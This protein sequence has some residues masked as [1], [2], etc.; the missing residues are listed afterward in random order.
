MGCAAQRA[1]VPGCLGRCCRR[2]VRVECSRGVVGWW[3]GRLSLDERIA[4][5]STGQLNEM[6]FSRCVCC[7]RSPPH[8]AYD[9]H[10]P[11]LT[12]PERGLCRHGGR[13]PH[14]PHHCRPAPELR[15]GWPHLQEV[16]RR[17]SCFWPVL[18]C[19]LKVGGPP[20]LQE[21]GRG[22]G[23]LTVTTNRC[24]GLLAV[25]G[26]C[27][28]MVGERRRPWR[29]SHH[30]RLAAAT[31]CLPQCFPLPSCCSKMAGELDLSAMLPSAKSWGKTW[32]QPV[33]RSVPRLGAGCLGVG[34]TLCFVLRL[35][36]LQPPACQA[37]SAVG[38]HLPP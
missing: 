13:C 37:C 21:V 4:R 3:A 27:G 20:G 25:P 2:A 29:C 24:S 38:E 33:S 32:S 16:S 22:A 35:G 7:L 12:Q 5:A 15:G 1:A 23:G 9:G 6:R 31:H 26:H 19:A 11:L 17:V 14:R 18:H 30:F 8:A 28:A 36:R 10:A 34:L